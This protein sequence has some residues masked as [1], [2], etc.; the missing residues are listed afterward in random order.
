[1][2][3]KRFFKTVSECE[4]TFRVAPEGASE[5]ALLTAANNWT[6]IP[7][8]RGKSGDFQARLRLPLD[9]RIQ[10]R[11]LVDGDRWINDEAADAYVPNEHGSENSIVDTTR[12]AGS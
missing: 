6:P 10:F 5:V 9:Q 11:Y 3:N 12:Q 7:M 4:V 1:M 2:L 8:R